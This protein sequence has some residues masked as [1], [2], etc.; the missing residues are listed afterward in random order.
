MMEKPRVLMAD[1][2]PTV[3]AGVRKLI[4][5]QYE[6]LGMVE[7]GQALL[8]AAEQLKPDLILLDI[9]MPLLDGFKATRR[10]KRW[11]PDTKFLFLTTH[12]SPRYVIEAFKVGAHGFLLKQSVVSELY[13]AIE[14]VLSGNYYVT[15][16][17]A[18]HVIVQAPHTEEKRGVRGPM[19]D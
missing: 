9:S 1:H 4:E 10:I 15:P 6:V 2:H 7:D 18:K 17:L 5:D 14:A 16:A 3:L 19:V 11:L 12:A 8:Q 13:R